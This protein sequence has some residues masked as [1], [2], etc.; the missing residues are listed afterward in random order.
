MCFFNGK[1]YRKEGQLEG[2][3]ANS[4]PVERLDSSCYV[5]DL[6]FEKSVLIWGDS[7][8]QALSPGIVHFIPKNWQVLQVA[9]SGCAPN[10]NVTLPSTTNQCDQSNYF[11]METIRKSRPDVVV[12]AQAKNHSVKN[13]D[14]ISNKLQQLGVK[15]ILFIGPTPQWTTDLPKIIA[16]QLWL[17]Q[18][19]VPN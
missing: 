12:V 18:P 13:M 4:K 17:T 19:N 15:K 10:P 2:G 3:V 6:H 11:A 9:S 8:A 1:K 5:R 16:R 7:H 14:E